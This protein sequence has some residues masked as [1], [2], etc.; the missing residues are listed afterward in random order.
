MDSYTRKVS[1]EEAREGF[2]L[3]EKRALSF[4]PPVGEPFELDG[5][6]ACIDAV[7]CTCRGPELPHEHWH[8]RLP[9]LEKGQRITIERLGPRRMRR[10]P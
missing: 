8:L 6:D 3:V 9:G 5:R 10:R 2:L 7:P 4:F 1:S